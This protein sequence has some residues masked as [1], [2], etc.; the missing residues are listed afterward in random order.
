[1]KKKKNAEIA[2]PSRINV[3]AILLIVLGVVLFGYF[4]TRIFAAGPASL[5]FTPS[6]GSYT[7][8]TNLAVQVYTNTGG[9]GV[10]AVQADFTY[11][12]TKLQVSSVDFTGSAFG[13]GDGADCYGPLHCFKLSRLSSSSL[14][15]HGCRRFGHHQH[16]Y[17][18]QHPGRHL[19][20]SSWRWRHADPHAAHAH[21]GASHPDPGAGHAYSH[22]S[23]R[24]HAHA[25]RYA[26]DYGWNHAYA[27]NERQSKFQPANRLLQLDA[28]ALPEHGS[29]LH[30]Y[31]Q[32]L[33]SHR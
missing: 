11:P 21:A 22:S 2:R 3:P 16:E 28:A 19:H 12:T 20:G 6:S 25:Y 23:A 27:D 5:Y 29:V 8:G 31:K 32:R 17:S 15:K 14:E 18:R 30:Q 24:H 4:I 33:C 26:H 7:A 1:M 10:N 9:Q 13:I